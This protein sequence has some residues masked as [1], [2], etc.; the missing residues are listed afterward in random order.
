METTMVKRPDIE[1]PISV[2]E[3]M[4][5]VFIRLALKKEKHLAKTGSK[6]AK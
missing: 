3:S 2:Y 5:R 1:I 6:F 4:L